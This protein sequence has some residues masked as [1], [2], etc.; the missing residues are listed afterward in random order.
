MLVIHDGTTAYKTEYG[1]I[2]TSEL[3]TFDVDINGN[4]VRVLAG[5]TTTNTVEFKVYANSLIRA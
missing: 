2:F 5:V 3:S 4:D 1:S